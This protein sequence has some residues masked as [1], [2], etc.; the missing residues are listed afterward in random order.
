M[1]ATLL[2]DL[3]VTGVRLLPTLFLVGAPVLLLLIML[4]AIIDTKIPHVDRAVLHAG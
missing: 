2:N 1:I 4:A 3:L